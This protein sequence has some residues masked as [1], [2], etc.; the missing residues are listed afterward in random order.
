VL[1]TAPGVFALSLEQ[2]DGLDFIDAGIHEALRLKCRLS[3]SQL[4][5]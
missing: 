2:I 1:H 4:R 3:S 5:H